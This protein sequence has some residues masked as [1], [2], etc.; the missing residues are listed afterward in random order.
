MPSKRRGQSPSRGW[1]I[2]RR[3]K[4]SPQVN[5]RVRVQRGSTVGIGDVDPAGTTF[6]DH[7]L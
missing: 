2:A 6:S 7:G 3:G 5:D 1:R 4:V